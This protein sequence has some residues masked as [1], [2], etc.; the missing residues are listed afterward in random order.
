MP[1][2]TGRAYSYAEKRAVMEKILAGWAKSE[3][4]QLG[5]FLINAAKVYNGQNDIFYLEDEEL[6]ASALKMGG[7]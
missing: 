1:K 2:I 3:Y 6:A 5:Q 4:Q 7:K